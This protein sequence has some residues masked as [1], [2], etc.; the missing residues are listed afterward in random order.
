MSNHLHRK[1]RQTGAYDHVLSLFRHTLEHSE[2]RRRPDVSA[3]MLDFA[4][5]G[6]IEQANQAV[7][8]AL[9]TGDR[10]WITSDLHL[11][12][13]N[14]IGY[15]DRPQRDVAEM[16]Q[17][18]MNLLAKVGAQDWIVLV[19]DLAMGDFDAG[20]S[21]IK[22][23]PGRKILVLGNH[24]LDRSGRCRLAGSVDA[25]GVPLFEFVVPFLFWTGPGGRQ[26]VVSHY[27]IDIPK[28]YRTPSILNY[29]GH[30]HRTVLPPSEVVKYMNVGWDVNY[31]LNCL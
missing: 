1:A 24:D 31:S 21:L 30:L 5:S 7:T 14:I 23:I 16:N 20:I 17:T 22:Q 8:G 12:H 15:C 3:G 2:H 10:V 25:S 11:N 13:A 27:P 26:V 18:L 4:D 6:V 9:A 29:H 28:G 19:G